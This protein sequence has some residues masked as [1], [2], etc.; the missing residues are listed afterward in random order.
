MPILLT[1]KGC[2]LILAGVTIQNETNFVSPS[3]SEDNFLLSLAAMF[4]GEFSL[5][6]LEELAGMKA[7]RILS[8][9]EQEVQSGL[10]TRIKPAVYLFKN[11]EQREERFNHLSPEEKERYH[12]NMSTIFIRDLHDDDSKALEIAEH[13][14]CISNGWNECQWL[15]RAGE[16][17]AQLLRT[18]K[19]I[20]CFTHVLTQL[21]NQR[22]G[23]EDR[24][25]IKAAI[26]YSNVYGGRVNMEQCLSFLRE[27]SE[28]AKY[29]HEQSY[30][31]LLEMHIA[32]YERLGSQLN[33]ATERFEQA[34]SQVERLDDPELTAS[35]TMFHTYFLFWQGRY[36]E[37]VNVY[38]KSVPDV[39]RYPIGHF[40]LI[41]AMMVG[42]CY[43]MVGQITQGLGLLDAIRNY[44]YQKG[45]LYL[46][47]HADSSIAMVML[48]T[49]RVED[50]LRYL[51]ISLK[52]AEESANHWV[53]NLVTLKLALVYHHMGSNKESLHYL[54]RF[55]R[56][57]SGPQANLLLYPYLMELCYAIE[58]GGLPAVP[59]LSLE[60]EIDRMLNIRNIFMQGIAYR[61]KA[62]LEKSRGSANQEI[63]RLF[64]LSAKLLNQSGNQIELAKTYLELTRH[65]L[66]TGNEKKGKATMQIASTILSSTNIGLIPDDLKT[67]IQD[68]NLEGS[69][70][71]E[72]MNLTDEIGSKKDSSRLLQHIVSTVNRITGA[73]RG[74]LLLLDE[75]RNPPK[76]K[77]RASK[78]LTI[79]QIYDPAFASSRKMIEEVIHSGKGCIFEI[80]SSKNNTVALQMKEQVRSSIC[81]PLML[82]KKAIGV[83]YHENRLLGNVFKE[84]DL[85]LLAFFAALATLDLDGEKAYQEIDRLL[86]EEKQVNSFDRKE[87]IESR[88]YE[89]I[90]GTSPAIQQT[91][92][93]IN[94]I[95]K[96]DT[97]VLILGETG[98]GKNL[99]AEAIHRQSLR[100]GG[101]FITVQCSALTESLITSEL[102]GHEKGAF[103]GAT[104]RYVGRFE[105]AHKGTLFLDEIGD[106]SLE[107]QARLLRVLQSKEFERVGGG[108]DVLVSDFRLIA[109][110]NRN[111]EQEVQA[112]RFREDL[113]YR[114]NVIPLL[115]PPLRERKEDIPLL[116]RH[117]LSLNNT[118][119]GTNIV[120]IKQETM[121]TLARHNWPGNIRE[122]EN[123]I[124]RGL[125]VG[126]GSYFQLPSLRATEP[127]IT[128]NNKFKTLKE[129]EHAHILQA[130]QQSRWKINGPGGAAQILDINA[131]TLAFRMKKLGIKKPAI[132]TG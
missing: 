61:Y 83:L 121:D 10:L 24:I 86:K 41:A 12:R 11:N 28:R 79:E 66:S 29:L 101:P 72:I 65:Y 78:N 47:A 5:D 68:Q 23:S 58:S 20:V 118:K 25:F 32:K 34:F 70:L 75:E 53:G 7:S 52:E 6:W 103:T 81:V 113:Y 17:H 69:I 88:Q 67:L 51:K 76:L 97:A 77:L 98:V 13:L 82:S 3:S 48:S 14:L 126:T 64:T 1:R 31:L 19:A 36:R 55:L 92:A 106:L 119:Q 46:S 56:N 30:E 71:T 96:T 107:V 54:R 89:G 16:I 39:E 99:L 104:N 18:D 33:K 45:D 80:G 95:A 49:N 124:Q 26:G 109:A 60:N 128:E 21:S 122:L 8:L 35:T 43:A 94:Q 2:Y 50:T 120:K 44:C 110:T 105:M 87:R 116:V 37:V 4:K 108:K 74:A 91:L 57:N 111:L 40:P 114:I 132:Y 15:I 42:H 9:L 112:G 100:A 85:K 62:L 129:Q 93:Q 123:V 127:H 84:Y 59:G 22:G 125:I 117:F 115:I 63:I 102:F 130:L 90:I 131:S 73:E 38:E 27:A